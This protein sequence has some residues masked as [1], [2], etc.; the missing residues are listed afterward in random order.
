MTTDRTD[1]YSYESCVNVSERVAW[2][3]ADVLGDEQFDMS[4]C[5]LPESLAQVNGIECLTPQEKLRLNQI[6]GLSYAHLFGFVEEF[7]VRQVIALA[8]RY[9]GDQ[10]IE[11]RALLRF[12][13]EEVKHQLLFA[14]TKAALMKQL[15]VCGLVGGASDV[16]GVVLQKSTL[17]VL[18]LIGMLE[19]MTQHHYA[20][21]F[22][23]SQEREA[24]DP[25][26][27]EIF[28]SHWIEEAQ[29]AKLGHLEIARLAS[30][31]SPAARDRAVDE[32]L[33]IG[34]AFDGLLK[35]QSELDLVALEHFR[36]K[37]FEADERTQIL[38]KQHRAYRYTFL[39]SGL[40]HKNVVEMVQDVSDAGV[41]KFAVAATALS[42]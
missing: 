21:M 9:G 22:R 31:S 12:A 25:T 23:S 27:V 14:R 2:K 28:K 40:T 33:E 4:R 16:A 18:I 11:R 37:P 30:Q 36:G 15:G 38:E 5:F 3:V 8:A 34:G 24:L 39:V 6:R 41:Q 35:A 26:F 20:D 10:P 1:R 42:S 19:W 7:I 13:E 29:H 32:V 17:G